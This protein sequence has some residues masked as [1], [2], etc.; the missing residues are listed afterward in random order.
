MDSLS[1]FPH[2]SAVQLNTEACLTLVFEMGTSEP[3]PYD[4]PY[5]G[6]YLVFIKLTIFS[7]VETFIYTISFNIFIINIKQNKVINNA[8]DEKNIRNI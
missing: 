6:N 1:S 8:K 7:S 3:S 2:I 5:M 4:R